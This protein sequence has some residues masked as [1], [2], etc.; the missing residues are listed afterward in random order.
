MARPWRHRDH[1]AY[2]ANA[3]DVG[4][5]R[6]TFNI[7]VIMISKIAA[8]AAALVLASAATAS[9]QPTAHHTRA[10]HFA[11]GVRAYESP[12]PQQ[13]DHQNCY[14]PSDACDTEHTVTN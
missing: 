5:R 11:P 12:V 6:Q 10:H 3:A 14:L 13:D 7:E 8:L 4:K 9:A 2:A 1:V